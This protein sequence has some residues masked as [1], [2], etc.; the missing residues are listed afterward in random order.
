MSRFKFFEEPQEVEQARETDRIHLRLLPSRNH[1]FS[2][3]YHTQF[4]AMGQ[5]VT[6][7]Q[8]EIIWILK[9][10]DV[11]EDGYL[12]DIEVEN[13]EVFNANPAFKEMIEF[14]K[15]FNYPTQKLVIKLNK[16]G[17]IER[18][19]NQEEIV[20][21]W[22]EI[23]GDVLEPLKNTAG[24]Q[25]LLKNGDQQFGDLLPSLKETLL[26]TV[27][28]SPVLGEKLVKNEHP[29]GEGSFSSQLFQ[30]IHVPYQ[31]RETLQSTDSAGFQCGHKAYIEKTVGADL[32]KLYNQSYKE[33]CGP[34][35]SYEIDYQADYNFDWSTGLLTLC[36]AV[37]KEKAND[38]LYFQTDFTIKRI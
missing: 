11:F 19:L 17:S 22:E 35:F 37:F 6:D 36:R 31:I 14:S 33:L 8:T 4:F 23:K 15:A 10:V 2:I 27:F 3:R 13:H 25:E 21:R 30:G 20:E 12:V 7:V 5:K 29:I 26:Y 34:K 38:G 1:R 32:T 18:V 16:Q 24:D 28:F 9:I